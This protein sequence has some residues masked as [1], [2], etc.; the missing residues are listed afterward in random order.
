MKPENLSIL[1]GNEFLKQTYLVHVMDEH[2]YIRMTRCDI[3][4]TCAAFSTL[5]SL[6]R[7]Y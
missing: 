7:R 1:S 6:T 5:C 3:T 2:T 4:V